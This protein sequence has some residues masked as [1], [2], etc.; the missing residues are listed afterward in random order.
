MERVFTTT[1][2]V[3]HVKID[4][5]FAHMEDMDQ[6]AAFVPVLNQDEHLIT[7]APPT[8]PGSD[9]DEQVIYM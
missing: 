7:V 5:G 9:D 8:N 6:T 1:D 3:L 2:D 4:E